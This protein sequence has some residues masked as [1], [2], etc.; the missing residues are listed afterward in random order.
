M[1]ELAPTLLLDG[2]RPGDEALAR[3]RARHTAARGRVLRAEVETAYKQQLDLLR[4]EDA[5]TLLERAGL[6]VSTTTARANPDGSETQVTVAQAPPVESIAMARTGLQIRFTALL[7]HSRATWDKALPILATALHKPEATVEQ[8][9]GQFVLCLNDRDPFDGVRAKTP[10]LST[11]AWHIGA[12]ETGEP[13]LLS[14]KNKSGWIVGGLGGTG[15]TALMTSV[16]VPWLKAGLMDLRVVDGKFGMDWEHLR[17]YATEFVSEPDMQ[18]VVRLFTEVREIAEWRAKHFYEQYGEANWWS[19]PDA[20]RSE[21]PLIAVLCDEFQSLMAPTKTG[22]AAADKKLAAIA[23]AVQ[24]L[25]YFFVTR[26][27]SLGVL[28]IGMSQRPDADAVPTGI[29]DNAQLRTCLRVT[30]RSAAT[31]ALGDTWDPD[32]T[33]PAL[34]PVRL[35]ADKPGRMILM[36]DQGKFRQVQGVYLPADQVRVELA[37]VTPRR[38]PGGHYAAE[39]DEDKGEGDE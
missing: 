7:G 29:R 33:G 36:D 24:S 12:D 34:D 22:D 16:V 39:H 20:V 3:V 1:A 31:M 32:E 17:P 27:R 8:R 14:V 19:L 25:V 18:A 15:K 38:A 2:P 10:P 35:P 9:P 5:F 37:D 21:H 13:V 23:S 11:T 28:W 26:C 4:G 30:K 6:I